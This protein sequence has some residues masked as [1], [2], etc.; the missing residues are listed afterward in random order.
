MTGHHIGR[1][2]ELDAFSECAFFAHSFA[3]PTCAI[4][5]PVEAGE[6]V[7]KAST[8]KSSVVQQHSL[9]PGCELPATSYGWEAVP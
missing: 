5:A 3:D 4:N 1:G 8:E 9:F 7:R 2:G 6:F